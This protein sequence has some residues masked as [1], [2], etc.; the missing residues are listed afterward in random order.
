MNNTSAVQLGVFIR[1]TLDLKKVKW[2]TLIEFNFL[3]VIS[4]VA[5]SQLPIFCLW[6]T[7]KFERPVVFTNETA[8]TD[9]KTH[10]REI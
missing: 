3:C 6:L 7:L 2:L 5:F 10:L 4:F 8:H 1:L 9:T